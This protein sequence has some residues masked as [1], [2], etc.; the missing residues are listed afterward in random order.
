MPNTF[1]DYRKNE[2][3][4]IAA[5]ALRRRPFPVVVLQSCSSLVCLLLV[6][7]C[8]SGSSSTGRIEHSIP[9]GLYAATGNC[10][11]NP[12]ANLLRPRRAARIDALAALGHD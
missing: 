9:S 1:V 11:R 2:T 3:E 12:L 4:W 7:P 10:Y 6:E 5:A 8:P